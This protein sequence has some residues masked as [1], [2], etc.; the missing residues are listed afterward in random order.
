MSCPPT[1]IIFFILFVRV[2][3]V[4]SPARPIIRMSNATQNVAAKRGRVKR[5]AGKIASHRETNVCTLCFVH[6]FPGLGRGRGRG[7]DRR[8]CRPWT[9]G[10][11]EKAAAALRFHFSSAA[12][13]PYK[14][15][16][17]AAAPVQSYDPRPTVHPRPASHRSTTTLDQPFI[18]DPLSAVRPRPAPGN[19]YVRYD[20]LEEQYAKRL[21][22]MFGVQHCLI[23]V[24]P[25][26][27]ILPPKYKDMG[28]RIRNMEVRPDD[29]WLVSYPR[30]GKRP[31]GRVG[32][33]S[34]DR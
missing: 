6:G 5:A 8:T 7:R 18:H 15:P 9:A 4:F 30:T 12:V 17:T 34:Y 33:E 29:V 25:G 14:N 2:I 10:V 26:K 22:D 31:T 20:D 3:G 16:R 24:N 28:Q 1:G 21:D 13:R 23:E 27:C 19:M 32:W 11:R